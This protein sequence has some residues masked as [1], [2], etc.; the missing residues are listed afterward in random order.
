MRVV[1]TMRR[2]N[3]AAEAIGF[4]LLSSLLYVLGY[5][6]SKR[7]VDTCQLTPVQVTFLRCAL[8]LGGGLA[9]TAWPS[10][11]LTWRRILRPADAWSSVRPQPPS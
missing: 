4:I 8:V 5:S 6:L 2:G 1:S 7:L 3:T 10:S 9:T 11:G